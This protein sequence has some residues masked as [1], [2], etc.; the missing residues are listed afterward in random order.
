MDRAV[1][2]ERVVDVQG[3]APAR[4]GICGPQRTAAAPAFASAA[5]TA[6]RLRTSGWPSGASSTASSEMR[7]SSTGT[8]AAI[9]LY[10]I[11]GKRR[12]PL[13][14]IA[15]P[16]CANNLLNSMKGFLMRR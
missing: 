2:G 13:L 7:I 3:L 16:T 4:G 15:S 5:P 10:I 11:R 6:P 14:E 12:L 9:R 8:A 1:A